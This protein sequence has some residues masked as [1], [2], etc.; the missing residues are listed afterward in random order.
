MYKV[1]VI[2]KL[3][4]KLWGCTANFKVKDYPG[5]VQKKPRHLTYFSIR[6]HTGKCTLSNFGSASETKQTHMI[7]G[8][9]CRRCRCVKIEMRIG[10]KSWAADYHR[11][12]VTWPHLR[13]SRRKSGSA[14]MHV[15]GMTR[16]CCYVQCSCLSLCRL[17]TAL[18]TLHAGLMGYT[19]ICLILS[20]VFKHCSFFSF[21]K[22]KKL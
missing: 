3:C 2:R 16:T 14:D 6:Q 15:A 10:L 5:S 19:C 8:K 11:N 4:V 17:C 13:R 21:L 20:P 7:P 12:V 1:I 18:D 9:R 22:L